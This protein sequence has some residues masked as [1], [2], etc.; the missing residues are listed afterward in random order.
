MDVS[1]AV[2]K[3]IFDEM[4]AEYAKRKTT[5]QRNI[6]KRKTII[7]DKAQGH[8]AK[9]AK[10]NSRRKGGKMISQSIIINGQLHEHKTFIPLMSKRDSFLSKLNKKEVYLH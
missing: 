7:L 6:I 5:N 4:E 8:D 9:D 2:D 3:A 1:V 10:V